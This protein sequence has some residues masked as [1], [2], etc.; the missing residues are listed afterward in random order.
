MYKKPIQIFGD[1][2]HFQG[3]I[4]YAIAIIPLALISQ[5]ESAI[6]KVKQQYGIAF[7]A[8]IHC[9][10]LFNEDK[11]KKSPC[12]HLSFD[13]MITLLED[14]M[15]QTYFAGARGWVGYL[16]SGNAPD[17]MLFESH[18]NPGEIDVIDVSSVKA[19]T[20]FTSQAAMAPVTHFV[21]HH[22]VE[23]WVDHEQTEIEFMGQK[24]K[25]VDSLMRFFP[26]NHNDEMLVPTPISTNK[27]IFLEVADILAYASSHA[28][29]K[30]PYNKKQKFTE[31]VNLIQ[32]GYSEVVF[33][34]GEASHSTRNFDRD[35]RIQN[36]LKSFI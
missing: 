18:K 1:E 3:I 5:V 25:R 27:P 8:A 11:K 23:A 26:I 28:L 16:D 9:S 6:S 22:L 19:R 30:G 13:Q 7:D 12:S 14:L 34:L 35:D 17:K 20:I 36:Y 21:S 24:R 33:E 10:H 29:C 32:P 15:L 31:I 2:S 4:T